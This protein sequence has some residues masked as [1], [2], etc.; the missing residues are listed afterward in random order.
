MTEKEKGVLGMLYDANNDAEL[1]GEYMDASLLLFDYNRTLTIEEAVRQSILKE[2]LGKIGK[3][4]ILRPPFYCDRGYNIELGDSVFAN[5]NFVVL[6]GGKV[7]IGN[8]VYIAPNVGIYTAGHPFDV[9]LRR[10][11][12]EYAYPVSIGNDVWIGAG[13]S[14]LP[15]VH[16]GNNVVIG[17]GS[18]VNRD[19]PDN[20]L[21]VGNPCKVIRH[22]EACSCPQ[23]Y[24]ER[25]VNK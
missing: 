3:G 18:V 12:L 1:Q 16:I 20:S 19:I 9:A 11:G 14:I 13:V 23:F 7:T 25:I 4:C 8:H 5:F 24:E 6:D 21:A 2:L 17:A 10:K 15:G 22:L